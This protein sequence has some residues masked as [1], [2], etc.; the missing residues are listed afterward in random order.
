MP[1]LLPNTTISMCP[2]YN[3][4]KSPMRD[5]NRDAADDVEAAEEDGA[6]GQTPGRVANARR[7]PTTSEVGNHLDTP[8]L[9]WHLFLR[10]RRACCRMASFHR[11]PS[12][13]AQSSPTPR[14]N[15]QIGTC[16]SLAGSTWRKATHQTRARWSG[17]NPITKRV[18][19]ARMP[20]TTLLQGTSLAKRECTRMCYRRTPDGVGRRLT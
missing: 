11:L 2:Q 15:T 9:H 20:S 4:S 10:S 8:P 1:N 12:Y 17:V 3:R 14:N 16:A 18:S 6:G 5:S 19:I 7:L 13:A